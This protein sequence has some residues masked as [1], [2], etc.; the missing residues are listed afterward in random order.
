MRK[1]ENLLALISIIIASR[2]MK[3]KTI[4]CKS[5]ESVECLEKNTE[6]TQ[7]SI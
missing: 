7:N 5:L 3:C 2:I 4:K 6:Y 1:E